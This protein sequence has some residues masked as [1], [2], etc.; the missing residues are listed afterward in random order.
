[1]NSRESWLIYWAEQ[2]HYIDKVQKKQLEKHKNPEVALKQMLDNEKYFCIEYCFVLQTFLQYSF[3]IGKINKQ[4]CN[5]YIAK[6]VKCLKEGKRDYILHLEKYNIDALFVQRAFYDLYSQHFLE[7]RDL[8][9]VQVMISMREESEKEDIFPGYRILKKIGEGGMG[10]VFK[11]LQ[12]RT[13]KVVA[14]KAI[15]QTG[16]DKESHLKRFYREIEI[17]STLK[18]PGIIDVV[19]FYPNCKMPYLVMEYIEGY[20]LLDYIKTCKPPI[21]K[22]MEILEQLLYAL[23]YAHQKQIFHRDIKP[24]NILIKRDGTPI[25]MDFGLAKNRTIVDKSLTQSGQLIGTPPYMAP[26]QARGEKREFDSQT[27]IYQMGAVLYH[28]L[29]GKPPASGN[30][31]IEVLHEVVDK[32]ASFDGDKVPRKLKNICKK[33]LEK[34]KQDRYASAKDFALDLRNY[35]EGNAAFATKFYKKQMGMKCIKVIFALLFLAC[36]IR[37]FPLGVKKKSLNIMI[38]L[39]FIDRLVRKKISRLHI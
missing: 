4:D 38:L 27:D 36:V 26:E 25:L 6:K 35:I 31:M 8:S 34:K 10:V 29:T 7:R 5:A 1:M 11:A 39:A 37:Y 23:E 15:K 17:T 14:I 3:Q 13:E 16:V 12:Q 30:N 21:K 33:A 28:I 24:S 9:F 19:E 20:T 32:K 2:F 18:H 22:K